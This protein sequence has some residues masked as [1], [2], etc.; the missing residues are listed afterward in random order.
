MK[1]K[2]ELTG[3]VCLPILLPL[4]A[5]LLSCAEP[6]SGTA[7]Q[8]KSIKEVPETQWRKLSSKSFFFGHQSV[9]KNILE[10]IND[11]IAV[12][13]SIKIKLL[14][15]NDK[16][17]IEKGVLA[18]YRIG[19]NLDPIF[20][21]EDFAALM[22]NGLGNKVDY[23]FVKLC[24]L[25]IQKNTP[26]ESVFEAYVRI[27]DDLQ[28]KYPQTT[29]IH[30]TSPLTVSKISWKTEIKKRLRMGN[31][32]ELNDNLKRDQFNTLLKNKYQ[33]KQPIFDIAAIES[34]LPDG[35]QYQFEM[36][37]KK[38]PYL[39][40][41]FTTD[42]GHLNKIGREHVAEQLLLMLLNLQ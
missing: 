28:K 8:Y 4:I 14:E 27:I 10:G 15:T 40:P 16:D 22:N 38:Y 26:V 13:P 32:W 17:K 30:F 11:L 3:R 12:N 23:A 1:I 24:Y 7:V 18:H 5:S 39:A 34:T 37:G 42:G 2:C 6:M 21:Y 9:G 33:G 29:F 19:A 25:D 36:D 20:K 31:L 41:E 35:K